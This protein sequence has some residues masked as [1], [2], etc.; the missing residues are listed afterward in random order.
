MLMM[1]SD[2]YII[3]L[4]PICE[5][6]WNHVC[7]LSPCYIFNEDTFGW[8]T[9]AHVKSIC[10]TT[11]R[12]NSFGQGHTMYEWYTEKHILQDDGHSKVLKNLENLQILH[13]MQSK[14]RDCHEW[15]TQHWSTISPVHDSHHTYNKNSKIVLEPLVAGAP[16]FSSQKPK[17]MFISRAAI[18]SISIPPNVVRCCFRYDSSV[19][20]PLPPLLAFIWWSALS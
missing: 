17:H 10:L 4:K 14:S 11:E 5:I 2:L 3:S 9:L 12:E 13:R 6:F 7:K 8:C 18:M 16:G 20:L 1:E 15:W 19:L